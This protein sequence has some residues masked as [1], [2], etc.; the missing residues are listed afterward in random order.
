M[1]DN[2]SISLVPLPGT[3]SIHSLEPGQPLPQI[4]EGFHSV[5]VTEE[6]KEIDSQHCSKGLKGLK[7]EGPLDLSLTGILHDLSKPLKE[8]GI[9]IFAIS[10]YDTD[11]LFIPES[12]YGSAIQVL[13]DSYIIRPE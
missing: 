4:Q 11:Y 3:Y 2:P 8:A 1:T 9:S 12:S 5:T 7:V 10:T 6:E 13:S